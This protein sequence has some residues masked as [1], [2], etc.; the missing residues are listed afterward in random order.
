MQSGKF[1]WKDK[2]EVKISQCAFCKHKQ[3][4]KICLAFNIIPDEILSN[5]IDHRQVYPGDNNIQFEPNEGVNS[6]DIDYLFS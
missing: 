4:G 1:S 5:S 2:L 6:E 3:M